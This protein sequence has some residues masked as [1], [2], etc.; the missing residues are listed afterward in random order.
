MEA[1][2]NNAVV[3]SALVG[4]KLLLICAI[5]AG[6]VSFVYALTL[7][8]YEANILE[9]KRQAIGA[10]FEKDSLDDPKQAAEIDGVVIYE[11]Y[12]NGALIGYCA[13][14][15]SAGFGGDIEMMIGY[16][17]DGSILG[18]EF[19]SHSETPGLGSKAGQPAYLEQYVG[20][21]GVLTLGTDV[22]AVSGATVSSRAVLA[23]VNAATAALQSVLS[24]GAVNE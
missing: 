8:Q 15:A 5:I 12:E 18:V 20:Q 22:D 24:G 17:S 19:I 11:V 6:V 2:K 4:L 21:S 23:G 7:E 14:V 3:Q 13:E 10:I 9:T 16:Q 1:T